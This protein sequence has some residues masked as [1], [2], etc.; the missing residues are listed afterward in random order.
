MKTPETSTNSTVLNVVARLFSKEALSYWCIFVIALGIR[1]IHQIS[2]SLYD[3]MYGFLLRG[4][5]NHTYDRWASEI[6]QAFL[7]G[8]ER[9]PFF[10]GPLYP[11]FLSLI[12]L[13]F[14]H[15]HDPAA[16]IQRG[17]GALTVVLIFYLARRVF[18]KKAGWF[19]GLGAA[20]SPL[21]LFYEGE[22]LVE[23][24][25]LFLH[26]ALLCILVVAAERRTIR[27]WLFCGLVL[28][29]CCVG[30]PN[31]LLL[32]PVAAVWIGAVA[33]G[34]WKGRLKSVTLFAVA[35]VIVIS[36]VT[37][38]NYVVGDRFFLVTYSG[39]YNLYIGNAPDAIGVFFTPPSMKAIREV[40]Q[41]ED[42]D[43][44][45]RGYLWKEWQSN[46]ML[47]PRKL[48]LKTRLYWQSGELPCDV[49]FYLRQPYSPFYRLPF[50]WA[51][52]APLGLVGL[53]SAFLRKSPRTLT[54]GRI[55]L[56][57]YLL[58]YS[59]SV[60][61]VFVPG[62][63][64]MPAL[65]VLFLFSGYALA[66]LVEAITSVIRTRQFRPHLHWAV[67]V[68]ICSLVLGM[69]LITPDDT[70]LIRWNDYFN[71]GSAYELKEEYENALN[72]YERAAERAPE[73]GSLRDI[74]DDMRE[75]IEQRERRIRPPS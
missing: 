28:G 75:R 25:L 8:W 55:I 46:P 16:W 15:H 65:A 27:W 36:P 54:D 6:S 40:E 48:W 37:L 17:V 23:T 4:G 12:Y 74:C 69:V 1:I 11:Y 50:R 49:N 33:A 67:A 32:L 10:H 29:I 9:I 57:T 51:F 72:Q 70:L 68:L 24:L 21:A 60:I 13:R 19:A 31:A 5:D 59:A 34:G 63:L 62:R 52:V 2:V 43:I 47:V 44:D 42:M 61:L 22:L 53:I 30:R 14:G 18:G 39:G 73:I 58:V 71:M 35:A 45:W 41:K 7:L 20:L 64:R 38:L 66:F 56:A 26:V 3:P